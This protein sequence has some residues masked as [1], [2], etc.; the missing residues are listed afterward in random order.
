MG[1]ASSTHSDPTLS[2]PDEWLAERAQEIED[3]LSAALNR[4]VETCRS[5][6]SVVR[7]EA[8]LAL[9]QETAVRAP[10]S[11]PVPDPETTAAM[12]EAAF[13]I[14]TAPAHPPL[15]DDSA[16]PARVKCRCDSSGA[17]CCGGYLRVQENGGSG[18]SGERRVGAGRAW[19]A[20]GGER[21]A[22]G[23]RR[24]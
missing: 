22:Q 2:D 7:L 8:A 13:L 4:L 10:H 3:A 6:Q 17:R 12:D 15:D 5:E 20:V 24:Q 14:Q 19:E 9:L 18:G 16:Q 11:V 23:S 1:V 21:A